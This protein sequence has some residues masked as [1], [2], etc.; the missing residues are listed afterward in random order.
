MSEDM[1]DGVLEFRFRAGAEVSIE[2]FSM[3][4]DK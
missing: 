4:E 1:L 2:S 3:T